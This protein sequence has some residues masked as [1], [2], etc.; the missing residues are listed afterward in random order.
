M[1]AFQSFFAAVFVLTS[2]YIVFTSSD[3]LSAIMHPFFLE[4]TFGIWMYAILISLAQYQGAAVNYT[5]SN[6][7]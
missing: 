1:T 7:R 3:P 5:M 2:M 6:H 4:V